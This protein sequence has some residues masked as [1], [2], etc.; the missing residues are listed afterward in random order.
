[1]TG[2]AIVRRCRHGEGKRGYETAEYSVW[3]NMIQRCTNANR[4][5]WKNYG[6]RGIAVSD[7]WLSYPSFLADMGRRPS[8]KHTLERKDNDKGYGPDNC[9]WAT[10][11]TQNNNHRRNVLITIGDKTM[12][13]TQWSK[14]TGI[15]RE[16]LRS[17][18]SRGWR[19]EDALTI[20]PKR[21]QKYK[22]M[23]ARS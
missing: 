4:K 19:M 5:E 10:R 21:G 18:I 16:A 13:L 17:R 7:R 14:T 23:E 1:M 15:P 12:N 2:K 9:V 6:G 22:A 20:R 8:S 11:D 3:Q